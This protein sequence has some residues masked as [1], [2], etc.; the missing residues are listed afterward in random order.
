LYVPT[1]N[2]ARIERRD[3]DHQSLG[4]LHL[5]SWLTRLVSVAGGHP[6]AKGID[7]LE[8]ELG[9]KKVPASLRTFWNAWVERESFQK[10]LLPAAQAF[11]EAAGH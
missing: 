10:V 3:A 7:A 1:T 8:S 2:G 9:E 5:I 4:D 6:D 11:I